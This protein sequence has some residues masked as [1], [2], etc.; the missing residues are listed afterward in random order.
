MKKYRV[1]LGFVMALVMAVGM[2]PF[3]T[4]A[5]AAKTPKLNATKAT[6][7]I[8]DTYMLSLNN[9]KGTVTWV[10]KDSKIAKVEDNGLVTALSTGKVK[11]YAK[12]SGKKYACTITVPK[13]KLSTT[14]YELKDGQ[15]FKLKLMN[16]KA[17]S[18]TSSDKAVATVSKKGTVKGY[19]LG[20]T[21]ITVKD[22]GGNIYKCEVTVVF[23]EE[24]HVHTPVLD[25]GYPS[26][27]TEPGLSNGSHC[28]VCGAVITAREPL[29]LKEHTYDE[30]YTCK[31]C[32]A[33]DPNK[34]HE[35]TLVSDKKDATCTEAGYTETVYCSTC[36]E[37]LMKSKEIKALG[38][39]FHGNVCVRC[40]A[41]CGV[42]IEHEWVT[43]K[44]KAP[45]CVESGYTEAVYCK[46]CG[47]VKKIS[48]TI[49]PLGH[50]YDGGATCIRCTADLNGHVHTWVE[51]KQIA[52]TCQ[53]PGMTAG[54]YC[55]TCGYREYERQF[56]KRVP[57]EYVN[58]K[59]RWCGKK[60]DE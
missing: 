9:A 46:N 11:V 3:S 33:I 42:T 43:E 19:H 35:H 49:P 37:V 40:N 23:N 45:T 58:G 39:D 34:P 27:C 16:A 53:E 47:F 20:D 22:A 29:P 59:C 52:P 5:H 24:G 38:H 48:E 8:G 56:I 60:E 55:S 4:D 12:Y 17:V 7:K 32:G 44:G 41:I 15:S 36:G 50:E 31:I 25:I 28:G 14:E 18:Y 30:N 13:A 1:L 51:E 6:V 26:T 21:V 57:H 54:R 10:S 2:L